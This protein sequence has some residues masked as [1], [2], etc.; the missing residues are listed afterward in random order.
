MKIAFKVFLAIGIIYLVLFLRINRYSK[1]YDGERSKLGVPL[2]TGFLEK[3]T[4]LISGVIVF[5]NKTENTAHFKK[6]IHVNYL[7]GIS[8]ETDIYSKS[9]L[10][11]Y[12]THYY[13]NKSRWMIRLYRNDER[14]QQLSYGQFLDTLKKYKID[15]N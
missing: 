2:V 1:Q 9:G 7:T 10:I 3:S 4:D 11:I 8:E 12:A 5:E 15:L 13:G 6:V 14:L